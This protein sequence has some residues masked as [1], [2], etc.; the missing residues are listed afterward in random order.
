MIRRATAADAAAIVDVQYQTWLD[1]Y[2]KIVDDVTPQMVKHR[3]EEEKGGLKARA[4]R[5]AATANEADPAV[6][7]AEHE[8]QVVGF[9]IATKLSEGANSHQINA[10]YVLPSHQHHGLGSQLMQ[11]ALEWLGA[12]VNPVQLHVVE[13]NQQALGFYQKFGFEVTKKMPR[14]D[15]T[16]FTSGIHMPRL[17]MVRPPT[18]L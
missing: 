4:E 17:E 7:V 12:A 10:L 11:T 6:F 18:A 8:G 16:V 3:F 1:V 15:S 14:A 5:F 2:P 13:T 9:A